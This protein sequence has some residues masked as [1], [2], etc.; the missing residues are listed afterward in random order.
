MDTTAKTDTRH[1]FKT[2][3]LVIV[4]G[5]PGSGKSHIAN[6]IREL[7]GEENAIVLDPDTIDK[8]SQE[9]ATLSHEL[10]ATGVDSKFYPYR[11]LRAKAY[12][13]ITH[14]KAIIWNQ[15]FTDFDGLKKTIVRLQ[16]FASEQTTQLPVLIVEVEIDE[17]V[18]RQRVSERALQ[19]GHDV[20]SDVF[21][22]FIS[23]YQSF[24]NKGYDVITV[25]GEDDAS[26]SAVAVID[27][28]EKLQK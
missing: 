22:R 17:A 10:S 2:P 14:S 4:R 9:Y 12:D 11:F 5:I 13:A 28:L 7:I 21:D 8:K 16:T 1:H 25:S 6:K 3:I 23:Q 18:A 26:Y 19:G 20:P 24:A 15:A 27:M